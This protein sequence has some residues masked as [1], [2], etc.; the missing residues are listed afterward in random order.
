MDRDTWR[1]TRSRLFA[2][3]IPIAIR[4]VSLLPW[5]R[6][7]ALGRRLGALAWLASRR[8]RARA[9]EHLALAFPELDPGRRAALGRACFEQHTT[10]LLET[11]HA[12]GRRPGAIVERI[13]VDGW[14]RVEG[15]LAAGRPLF[16]LTAHCGNWELVGAVFTA[17]GIPLT[18]VVREIDPGAEGMMR[19]LRRHYGTRTVV[20]GSPGA[21]RE[22]L[23]VLRSGGVLAMLIDQDVRVD[24]VWV[25][26]FGRLAYTPAGA[27][28]IA[29]RR[30]A[31]VVPIF[32]ERLDDGS[33]VMRCRP[34]LELPE[35]VEGATALMTA[36]IEEQVRRRP[37]QWVWMHRRWRQRP[38][39]EAETPQASQ[40]IR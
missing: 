39:G 2:I 15:P 20:R 29:L 5:R 13:R 18:G 25:P 32:M 10:N 23:R 33:H 7:L 24:G 31:T 30:G 19:R 21:A 22:L 36:A 8:D 16:V 27:A 28:Q 1:R 35:D 38:P 26:F 6:A 14:E 40:E 34:A 4:L 37:E 9:L 11:L 3:F 17:R 12:L